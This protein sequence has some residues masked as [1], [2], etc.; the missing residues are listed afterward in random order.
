M[1]LNGESSLADDRFASDA[2]DGADIIRPD[3]G[4]RHL[5]VTTTTSFGAN[6]WQDVLLD[7]I[8]NLKKLS[9]GWDS[10]SA[11]RIDL[12]AMGFALIVLNNI[13]ESNTPLP[14]VVPSSV[15]GIQLEWHERGI[16]LEIHVTGPYE[17]EIWYQDHTQPDKGPVSDEITIDFSQIQ[18]F[19]TE[20]TS[21]QAPIQHAV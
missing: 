13:M 1:P 17:G 15:G 14:Q 20:L 2:N 16:D 4:R 12:D 6:N 19:V 11:P 3:F 18:S 7:Q 21:R 10:Y 5:R 8:M 9:H